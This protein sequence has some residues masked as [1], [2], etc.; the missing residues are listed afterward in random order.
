MHETIKYLEKKLKPNDIIVAGISGG[1][2]SMCLLSLLIA[3]QNKLNLKIIVAHINHN[4]RPESKEEAQF[5][6]NFALKNNCLFE[7]YKIETYQND[8]FENYARKQR[9]DF[10]SQLI[11]KYHA[12]YLMTAH[13]GD[14]LIETILMRL[15]RGSNLD[16][17]GG[18]KKE[19]KYETYELLRPLINMTKD[20][21]IKYNQEHSIEYRF[22][23]SNDNLDFTRN[24][25]RKMILPLLKKEN[26]N[27]HQKF[28]S[29]SEEIYNTLQFLDN[30]TNNALTGVINFDK[31]NLQEFNKLDALLKKR[32]VEFILKKEY[33]DK[34]ILINK[35][36]LQKILELCNSKKTNSTINLPENRI[37]VKSYNYLYFQKNKSLDFFHALLDDKVEISQNEKIIKLTKCDIEKS[38]YIIRLNSK[39]IKLP[40]YVRYRKSGDIMEIKNLQGRKK[41]KDIFIDE[42]IAIDKR[43]SWPVVIDS[44]NT[45]LWLPGLKKSKFDKNSDEFYD[46]IY[47]YVISEEKRDTYDK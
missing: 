27:V 41:L 22:D 26:K 30:M 46:I 19:T 44:N 17:Y 15:V 38:N 10:F 45:I 28:L 37:L 21:I 9:Y 32:V 3:F 8:N 2:D 23:K 4:V 29:F 5:V 36:H 16:G 18:F 7:Y 40:L 24:R 25:Y 13:H 39:E 14:D 11:E 12:N 33:Q 31:V 43:A 42:K 6:K 1:P 34:I 35:I 20:D 47:K